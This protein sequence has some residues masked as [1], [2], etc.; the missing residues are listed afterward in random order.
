MD[1]LQNHIFISECNWGGDYLC[2]HLVSI[3][4][5]DEFSI[6]IGGDLDRI[7]TR[8]TY[9]AS[10]EVIKRYSELYDGE[11]NDA[12]IESLG[13]RG[14]ELRPHVVD[15]LNNNIKS[16]KCDPTH[17]QGWATH[18]CNRFNSIALGFHRR[19]DAMKF[20]REF[21]SLG[22][23]VYRTQYFKDHFDV[24]DPDTKKYKRR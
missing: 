11:L 18:E 9:P 16:R 6:G 4:T 23:P 15:W 13:E 8:V 10:D 1:Y 24:Y 2:R 14:Y 7:A 19:N 12:I 5:R 20:I 17:P 22:K 21:S 3:D